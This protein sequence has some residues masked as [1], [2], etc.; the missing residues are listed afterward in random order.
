MKKLVLFTGITVYLL[1]AV[2]SFIAVATENRASVVHPAK[3]SENILAQEKALPIYYVK[4]ID[5][6]IC[7]L[8]ANNNV[9]IKTDTLVSLLPQNDKIKLNQGIKVEGD[10]NL[11]TL[12]EDFCS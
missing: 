1:F 8:D 9:K 7:V 2:S 6:K 10:E 4:N 11:R 5:G 3:P 12:L